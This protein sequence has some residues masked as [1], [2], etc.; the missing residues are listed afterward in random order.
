MIRNE[1]R[2]V[3]LMEPPE[4]ESVLS[5]AGVIDRVT[6]DRVT[7]IAN[8]GT[9]L[10]RVSYSKAR[11]EPGYRSVTRAR[12]ATFPS[13]RTSGACDRAV[14]AALASTEAGS[15]T[16]G[17]RTRPHVRMRFPKCA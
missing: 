16:T 10:P 7:M 4:G 3:G 5:L 1:L 11:S 2:P 17:R 8:V 9:M 12:S 6:I 15:S 13:L 14:P